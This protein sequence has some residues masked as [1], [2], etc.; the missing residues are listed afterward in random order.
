MP[1]PD[2][3]VDGLGYVLDIFVCPDC[4]TDLRLEARDGL[5][6]EYVV[7][8]CPDECFAAA[9]R[10]ASRLEL[11]SAVSTRD[12]AGFC[13]QCQDQIVDEADAVNVTLVGNDHVVHEGECLEAH[14]EEQERAQA[15]GVEVGGFEESDSA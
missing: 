5:H 8:I 9:V 3:D 7:A 2:V 14:R 1:D 4:G 15:F 11:D 10:G 12:P 13:V 6:H